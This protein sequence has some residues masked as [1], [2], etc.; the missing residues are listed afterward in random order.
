MDIDN[1]NDIQTEIKH[2]NDK[3]KEYRTEIIMLTK[4]KKKLMKQETPGILKWNNIENKRKRPHNRNIERNN[5]NNTDSLSICSNEND[6]TTNGNNEKER[7]PMVEI[8]DDSTQIIS[9]KEE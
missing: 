1:K 7:N 3:I 6:I 4:R 5:H 8:V 9:Y 2:I